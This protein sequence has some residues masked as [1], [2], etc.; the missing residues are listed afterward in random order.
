MATFRKN[1]QTNSI[2]IDD[3]YLQG[4]DFSTCTHTYTKILVL[5]GFIQHPE[6]I[7]IFIPSQQ[8]NILGFCINSS[9]MIITY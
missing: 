3:I 5:L 8:I 1:R 9:S 2:Y 7:F 4:K 6:K